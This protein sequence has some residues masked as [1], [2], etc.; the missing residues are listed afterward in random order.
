VDLAQ[1]SPAACSSPLQAK[2]LHVLAALEVDSFR[3]RAL[4]V[5]N[6]DGSS[7]TSAATLLGTKA[8]GATKGRPGATGMAAQTTAAQTLAGLMTLDAAAAAAGEGGSTV[9]DGGWPR[10][11]AVPAAASS[12]A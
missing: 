4:D 11:V 1:K 7:K 2:K 5:G 3:R 10:S 8:A 9:V 12:A 6:P